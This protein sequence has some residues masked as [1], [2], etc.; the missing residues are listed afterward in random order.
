MWVF[1]HLMS[2]KRGPLLTC[3]EC[4]A[5]VRSSI[6]FTFGKALVHCSFVEKEI[7]MCFF[8]VPK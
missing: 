1:Y 3:L 7:Q 4:N 5:K 2:L 8:P 6:E